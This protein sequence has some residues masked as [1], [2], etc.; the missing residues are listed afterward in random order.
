MSEPRGLTELQTALQQFLLDPRQ[1]VEHLIAAN[2]RMPP[3]TQVGVYAEAYRARLAEALDADFAGL[4]AYLG[5]DEFERLVHA[6]LADHPSR[7]FSLRWFGLYLADFLAANLPYSEHPDISEMARFEWAQCDAFDAPDTAVI[8]MAEFA[9]IAALQ[10]PELRLGFHPSLVRLDLHANVPAL[11]LALNAGESPPA[12]ERLDQPQ[13]WLLWR[14]EL[15]VLFR[16]LTAAE[17][18]GLDQFRAGATFTTACEGLCQW[19]PPEDVP[20]Q[21]ATQLRRWVEDGLVIQVD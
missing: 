1:P 14:S 21:A 17:A 13:P 3:A 6:Y 8:G 9:A 5:D 20:L 2:A 7:H 4:H 10:W 11:W 18:F 12:L 16:P 19:F 15:R